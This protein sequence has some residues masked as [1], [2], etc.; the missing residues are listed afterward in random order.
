MMGVRLSRLSIAALF[1]VGFLSSNAFGKPSGFHSPRHAPSTIPPAGI[2]FSDTSSNI[3][4]QRPLDSLSLNLP[5]R[6]RIVLTPA[7]ARNGAITIVKKS[8]ILLAPHASTETELPPD[9]L[10]TWNAP[11]SLMLFHGDY[12]IL[13]TAPGFRGAIQSARIDDTVPHN[14]SINLL[15]LR[16]LRMKRRQWRKYKWISAGIAAG[17]GLAAILFQ[18]RITYFSHRYQNALTPS[19]AVDARQSV[20]L[21]QTL[22]TASSAIS[23][24]GLGGF[25]VSWIIESTYAN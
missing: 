10:G 4:S 12:D 15:S 23:F 9:T 21:S 16:Y 18:S 6:I 20:A 13:A 8:S 3:A 25:L 2:F 14:I 19:A 5:I 22:Y 17:A 1:I 7:A 11:L 24:S